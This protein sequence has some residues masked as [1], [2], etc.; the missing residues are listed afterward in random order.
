M[1]DGV[2]A[3]GHILFKHCRTASVPRT[4]GRR[5]SPPLV[6]LWEKLGASFRRTDALHLE[7]RQTILRLRAIYETARRGAL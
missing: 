6:E 3:L 7:P 5:E 4:T 2:D 1:D